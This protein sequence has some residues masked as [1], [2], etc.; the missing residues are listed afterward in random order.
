M[1]GNNEINVNNIL[2]LY[3]KAF[4]ENAKVWGR[5][6]KINIRL[7]NGML[8]NCIVYYFIDTY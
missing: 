7:R 5:S 3:L 1:L 8:L 4:N 2:G 6:L